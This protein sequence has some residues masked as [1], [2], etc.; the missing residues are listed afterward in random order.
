M[1]RPKRNVV[2]FTDATVPVPLDEKQQRLKARQLAELCDKI[3][4]ER[5]A[6]KADAGGARKKIR[7]LEDQRRLLAECVRTGSE[8]Q[9]AQA[10]LFRE[11]NKT[12]L[13]DE[14]ADVEDSDLEADDLDS[15][16][17][18]EED[19][20]AEADDRAIDKAKDAFAAPAASNGP[21]ER[22]AFLAN[23]SATRAPVT[24]ILDGR[25]QD[26]RDADANEALGE[27]IEGEAAKLE[28]AKLEAAAAPAPM[29]SSVA[30]FVDSWD[31]PLEDITPP[32][33]GKARGSRKP[34][35]GNG[36]TPKT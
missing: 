32:A 27:I 34:K 25:T 29:V 31:Q 12:R 11:P 10:E 15:A 2:T 23:K 30:D 14:D 21:D 5:A 18:G 16:L 22:D 17:L 7:A 33:T 8:K 26:E 13:L 9:N 6:A 19:A 3:D 4:S 20:Q 24:S 28:A 36:E 35:N 1:G